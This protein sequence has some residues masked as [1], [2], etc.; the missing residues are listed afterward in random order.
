[1]FKPGDIVELADEYRAHALGIYPH[2][3]GALMVSSAD[4]YNIGVGYY[5]YP[6]YWFK[7]VGREEPESA[8]HIP[9]DSEVR[10]QIPLFDGLFAYFPQALIE[11]A[12][13]SKVGNDKHNPGEALHWARE[14]STDHKNKI[15]RH[16]LDADKKDS[17]GF[18]EAVGMC[19]R[20]L[21][22]LQ[23]I[24]EEKEGRPYGD[25]ARPSS[26]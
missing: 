26:K 18:Y 9:D 7:L 4:N 11:V 12:K 19:W 10:E 1:M 8:R 13:W 23:T 14:K 16:L 17:A 20:S 2:L 5:L 15:L 24:L 25:N 3:A 22:L 6:T 21:A